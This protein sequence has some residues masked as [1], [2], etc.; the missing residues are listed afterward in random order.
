M[1]WNFSSALHT[2]SSYR[3]SRVLASQIKIK[4][5]EELRC[6]KFTVLN[7]SKKQEQTIGQNRYSRLMCAEIKSGF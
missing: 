7:E 2:I 5:I 6:K 3:S 1:I 4:K